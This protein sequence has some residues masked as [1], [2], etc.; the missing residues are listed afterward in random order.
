MGMAMMK[1]GIMRMVVDHYR[2]LVTMA[3]RLT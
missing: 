2:M 1:I 3:M